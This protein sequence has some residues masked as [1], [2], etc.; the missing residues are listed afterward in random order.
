MRNPTSFLLPVLAMVFALAV[1]G[2]PEGVA[3]QDGC[4]IC[5]YVPQEEEPPT[6]ECDPLP[7]GEGYETCDVKSGWEDCE[8]SSDK[9]DCGSRLALD[10]R[11][12]VGSGVAPAAVAI[13]WGRQLV[14]P[15]ADTPA[16]VTRQACTGAIVQRRYSAGSIA[17]L[18]AGLRH[19]TI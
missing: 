5:V 13:P 17:E 16:A 15:A 2:M 9:P 6:P 19:V 11:A 7:T 4:T 3:A 18:R 8:M 12:D 1:L 14:V 10:G